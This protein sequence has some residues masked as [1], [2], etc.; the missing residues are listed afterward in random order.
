[1]CAWY[2]YER[3]FV[4]TRL[5]FFHCSLFRARDMH[6]S[7]CSC[8]FTTHIFCFVSDSFVCR[9]SAFCLY[10]LMVVGFPHNGKIVMQRIATGN[11]IGSNEKKSELQQIYMVGFRQRTTIVCIMPHRGHA[12]NQFAIGNEAI[13]HIALVKRR[14]WRNVYNTGYLR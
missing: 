8:C 7:R 13:A 11:W 9:V 6:V 4:L 12:K 1:M 14:S 3:N 10:N 5:L 2:K